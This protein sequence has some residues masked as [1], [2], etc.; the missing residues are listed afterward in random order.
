MASSEIL[1]GWEPRTRFVLCDEMTRGQAKAAVAWDDGL[2]F[3][4][5]RCSRVYLHYREI[6]EDE[7]AQCWMDDW[8]EGDQ[9]WIECGRRDEGA[10]AW[11]C[12]TWPPDAW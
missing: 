4:D 2:A 5:L 3:V 6:T 1:D 12:V 8:R 10:T 9:G 11:W 7:A